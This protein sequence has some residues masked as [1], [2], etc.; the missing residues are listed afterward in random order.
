M[1]ILDNSP[2][3]PV[4]FFS[5]TVELMAHID[6]L[7]QTDAYKAADAA[8]TLENVQSY[9]MA[10]ADGLDYAEAERRTWEGDPERAAR[11][12]E[13]AR[14]L[15]PEGQA[16]SQTRYRVRR[17]VHGKKVNVGAYLTGAP[18]CMLTH[19]VTREEGHGKVMHLAI[20]LGRLASVSTRAAE[21]Y[22]GAIC[23]AVDAAEAAG[24]RIQLTA[25][26]TAEFTNG[27][28]M[29]AVSCAWP[30]KAADEPLDL[31]RL[32]FQIAGAAFHRRI[33][34]RHA[35]GE[36]LSH[37]PEAG[38][39]YFSWRTSSIAPQW[40]TAMGV[41]AQFPPNVTEHNDMNYARQQVHQTLAAAGI[42]VKLNPA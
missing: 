38:T 2:K 19:R 27:R 35:E 12:R 30:L 9:D 37:C 14:K 8:R 13:I 4:T 1:Q 41:D 42:E 24:Y 7:A 16:P 32:G 28:E 21:H 39:A 22:G 26:R 3:H 34:F 18:E 15:T 17:S 31:D 25:T 5:G 11:I 29:K 36:M 40:L 6:Q 23:A 20:A 10:F 33:L